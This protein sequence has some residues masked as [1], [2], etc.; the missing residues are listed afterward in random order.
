MIQLLAIGL[1]GACGSILR[2]L[3]AGKVQAWFGGDF[4]LGIFT[5][6]LLGS[7]IMGVLATIFIARF[8]LNSVWREAILIGVLG[9]FTTFS[10]FSMGVVNLFKN[11]AE[12]QALLY[13]FA[14]VL[15]C[16]LAAWLGV[17]LGRSL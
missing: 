6:N 7:F 15:F 9:G 2:F 4:P 12:L 8:D 14:S 5:V 10:G 11:G 16:V 3:T 13:I 1:G 17:L